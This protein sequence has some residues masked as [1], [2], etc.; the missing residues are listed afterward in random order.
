MSSDTER[1]TAVS[2][3]MPVHNGGS[4]LKLTLES[5]LVQLKKT[6]Q[7][8]IIDDASHDQS[9]ELAKK[10]SGNKEGTLFIKNEKQR[11]LAATYNVGIRNAINELIVTLHQDIVL[12]KDALKKLVEPMIDTQVVA[13]AHVVD[14]P[15]E[16]WK[17]Y[18]F[19]QKCFFSRLA[20]KKFHGVDGKFDCFRKSAL[21]KVG[22]FDEKHFRTAGEDGNVV[23]K[24]KKIGK[25]ANSE[26]QIV[27][28]HQVNPNFSWRDIIYKQAQ[29]SEAQ[30]VLL[31]VGMD[32]SVKNIIRTFAGIFKYIFRQGLRFKNRKLFTFCFL[33]K[34]FF[35]KFRKNHLFQFNFFSRI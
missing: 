4:T 31:R 15:L 1:A 5:F 10:N 11:G 19:W 14:H 32:R 34:S 21:E 17:Q 27:H 6:D 23:Y 22:L 12:N 26:A 24:L 25:I 9:L 30:G 33:R 18:N 20:G 13:S 28:I 35:S 2:V 3:I 16:I 7:L 29:Y 8:I